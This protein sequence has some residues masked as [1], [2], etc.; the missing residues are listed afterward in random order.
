MSPPPDNEPAA[1]TD[2]ARLRRI[3]HALLDR[4]PTTLRAAV[5][6]RILAALGPEE[7]QALLGDLARR[8]DAATW[9]QGLRDVA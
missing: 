8:A 9:L 7:A 6:R 4:V 1:R 3:E 2:G 5:L